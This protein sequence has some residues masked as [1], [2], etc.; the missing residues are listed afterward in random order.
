MNKKI[1]VLVLCLLAALVCFGFNNAEA[2]DAV[3]LT[4]SLWDEEQLPTVQENVDKFNELHKGEIEVT[5]EQIPWSSYWTKLDASLETKEA[6]DVFWMNVYVNKYAEAGTL[7]PLDSY[8]E[9]RTSIRASTQPA[10]SPP[11][12]STVSSTH[13]RRVLTLLSSP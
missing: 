1:F 12:T 2:D 3:K 4:L 5:I 11:I 7:E 8:I 9:K 13:C 10:V 6:P